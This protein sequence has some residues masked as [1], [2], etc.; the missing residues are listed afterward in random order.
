MS[1]DNHSD[2]GATQIPGSP[3]G[4]I[5]PPRAG[6]PAA[7]PMNTLAIIAFI[8]SFFVG[9]VG[10]VCGHIALSQITRT[11]ARGRGFAL[12]GLIIGYAEIA[13][14]LVVVVLIIIVAAAGGFSASTEIRLP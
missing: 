6:W 8:G 2:Y 5:T 3:A 13:I 10:I 14:S 4:Y 7:A 11:G 1:D 12:A 9:L